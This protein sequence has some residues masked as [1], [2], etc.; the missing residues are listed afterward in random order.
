MS[1]HDKTRENLKWELEAAYLLISDLEEREADLKRE[2]ESLRNR[3]AYF[4]AITRNAS[5]MVFVLDR[6]GKIAYSSQAVERFLG[7]RPEELEGKTAHEIISPEDI[8]RSMRDFARAV[9]TEAELIPN[10]FRIVHKD[11]SERVLEGVGANR[12]NDP[13]VNGFVINVRDVT[14]RKLAEAALRESEER[15]WILSSLS[16]EGI[17]ISRDHLIVD[18]NDT[19]VSMAGFYSLSEIIGKNL[20]HMVAPDPAKSAFLTD[21]Q[22]GMEGTYEINFLRRDESVFPA[23]FNVRNII[24][25]GE[26]ARVTSVRD[27]TERKRAEEALRHSEERYR[28]LFENSG[29]AMLIAEDNTILSLVNSEFEKLSGYT[30]EEIEGK[31]PFTQVVSQKDLQRMIGYHKSRRSEINVAPSEYEFR[32]VDRDGN[33]K[34]VLVKIAIMPGTK[35]STA[36]LLDISALKKAEQRIRESLEF[37]KTVFAA[38]PIGIVIFHSSGPCVSVNNAVAEIIGGNTKQVLTQ[39]FR[40]L[41]SWKES[42][43]LEAAERALATGQV[44]SLETRLDSSFGKSCW[45]DCR[46]APFY[47]EG[48][49]HLLLLLADINDRIQ[50]EKALKVSER[51]L[52]DIIDFLPDATLV[53]DKDG[54]L[55]AWNKAMEELAGIKAASMLGKGNYEYALPVHNERRPILVDLVL[56]PDPEAEKNYQVLERKGE[57]LTAEGYVANLGKYLSSTAAPLRDSEGNIVGAIQSTRDITDEKRALHELAMA[58]E[59]YRSIFENSMLG[60]F[61]TTPWGKVI[62]CNTAY[63]RIAGYDSPRELMSSI[64]DIA[65]IFVD[66]EVRRDYLQA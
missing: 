17:C 5:D 58:E 34:D 39:N 29:T 8:E 22:R 19:F 64:S 42:G 33:E 65:Q 52:A 59:K 60:I 62:S 32:F 13:A 1:N 56:H 47:H 51:R 24:Y 44:L 45:V 43:M 3:E 23:E 25:Q 20:L 38:S 54:I 10:S 7:Y 4:Q 50:A 14:G 61:Q 31:I 27:I 12:L 41:A 11:G 66:P 26:Y 63:A 35:Q 2:V 49:L 18:A 6:Q 46:F 9:R 16:S 15:N 40:E 57:V 37:N 21:I 36:A 48:E 30:R 53:I 55:I 28:S